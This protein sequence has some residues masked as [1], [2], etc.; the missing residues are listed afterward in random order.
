MRYNAGTVNARR[1]AMLSLPYALQ[2]LLYASGE[3]LP[4]KRACA[5]LS[6]TEDMLATAA[7][8]LRNL[9]AGTGLALVE[10]AG[11]L[12]LRTAAEAAPVI[13]AFR[14]GE[15][16][17]D[18]GKAS[19]ETLAIILYRGGATRGEV[20]RIRGV[21]STAAIRALLLR[22]LVERTADDADKRRARYS[23]TA[24][25][26]AHLGIGR[27]EDAPQWGTWAA[28]LRDAEAKAEAA[29]PAPAG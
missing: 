17:R 12:E 28:A 10:T 19:L 8:E 18:L 6:V 5:V 4:K 16:A 29:E 1:T 23:V 15:R 9:L 3:P 26:L 20:D 22:G 21:N 14:A 27:A 24:D 13:D 11:E 2:A 7:G 25:A